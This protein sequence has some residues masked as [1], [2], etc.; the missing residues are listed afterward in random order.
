MKIENGKT[1]IDGRGRR[2]RIIATDRLTAATEQPAFPIVGLLDCG[3]YEDCRTFTREG[4]Y[5]HSPGEYDIVREV[6]PY[7]HIRKG[8]VVLA[9]IAQIPA[10]FHSVADD[11]VPCIY[12]EGL[13]PWTAGSNPAILRVNRVEL[14]EALNLDLD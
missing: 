10:H 6:S 9:G 4:Q 11:G 3:A 13:S 7:E 1:Y 2:V 5:S 14:D 8:D 12:P